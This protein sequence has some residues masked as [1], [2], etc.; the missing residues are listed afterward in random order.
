[1]GWDSGI[2][3][4]SGGGLDKGNQLGP[5]VDHSSLILTDVGP[6]PMSPFK[7]KVPLKPVQSFKAISVVKR[8]V[9]GALKLQG[10]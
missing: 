1:M 9:F 10:I 4:S 6:R 7:S 3:F 5:I 8:S 2:F